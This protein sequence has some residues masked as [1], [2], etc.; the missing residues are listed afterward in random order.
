MATWISLLQ[1]RPRPTNICIPI[2]K[3]D[4]GIFGSERESDRLATVMQLSSPAE[5]RGT[6][7]E[8]RHPLGKR[9]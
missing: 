9:R 3:L 2:V 8:H 1:P 7:V 6:D 5:P 4:D